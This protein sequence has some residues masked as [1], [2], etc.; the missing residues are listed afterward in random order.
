[1]MMGDFNVTLTLDEHSDGSSIPS[2]D[3]VRCKPLICLTFKAAPSRAYVRAAA[4]EGYFKNGRGLRQGDP[5]FPYLF[6]MVMEM[7]NLILKNKIRENQDFKYHFGCTKLEITH[8]C[9]AD[10]LIVL[11]NCDI[12]SVKVIKNALEEFSSIYGLNPHLNKSI[13]FFKG[14]TNEEQNKILQILPFSVGKLPIRYLEVP[15]ITK[16]LSINDCKPLIE[17]IKIFQLPKSVLKDINKM[18]KGFLWCQGELSSGKANAKWIHEERLKGTNIWKVETDMNAS[19][20]WRNLLNFRGK[21]GKHVYH[22]IGNGKKTSVC[23]YD[24][25]EKNILVPN[26]NDEVEDVVRWKT[27]GKLVKYSIGQVWRDLN[28][29][30]QKVTWKALMWTDLLSGNQMIHLNALYVRDALILMITYSSS[31]ISLKRLILGASV[32]MIW[33]ERNTRL[34]Q[35]KKQTEEVDIKQIEESIKTS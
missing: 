25:F 16:Q 14:L 34:F 35:E 6:T 17:N 29:S 5:I 10:D 22:K 1:M 12:Q 33:K 28:S 19:W 27:E 31:V 18:F 21:V 4:R 24:S 15:L 8:L 30:T 13:V 3:I 32:Y 20:G 11:C 26:L 2:Q 23:N 9:F 7:F